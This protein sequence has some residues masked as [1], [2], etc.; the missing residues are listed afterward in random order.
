MFSK[1]SVHIPKETVLVRVIVASLMKSAVSAF[2]V[3]NSSPIS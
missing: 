3:F 2:E 1:L